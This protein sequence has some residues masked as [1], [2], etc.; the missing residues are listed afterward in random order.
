MKNHSKIGLLASILYLLQLPVYSMQVNYGYIA[1]YDCTVNTYK[2][3]NGG[4]LKGL[5][6]VKVNVSSLTGTGTISAG[7]YAEIKTDYFGYSGTIYSGHRLGIKAKKFEESAT[8]EAPIITIACDE[9]KFVGVIS[10]SDKCIIYAKKP[11]DKNMFKKSGE[12]KFKVVISPYDIQYFSKEG[13]ISKSYNEFCYNCLTLDQTTLDST[14]KRIR[15]HAVLNDI[16]DK[17]VLN[18]IKKKLEEKA[19]FHQARLQENQDMD[20]LYVGLAKCGVTGAGLLA[21]YFAFKH[22]QA[23]TTKF[24]ADAGVI[25]IMSVIAAACSTLPAAFSFSD[26]Y[27]WRNPR[28]QEK[29]DGFSLIISRIDHALATPRVAEEQII[30][31]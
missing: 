28:H 19:N 2:F 3:I 13:L 23:L 20:S 5:N 7:S 14:I 10:C 6:S 25:K 1:S 8:I 24:K 31:L 22:E 15:T 17:E 30:T 16:D 4:T 11:F 27:N 21:A 18:D 26:F 29:Y 12:G 9:F